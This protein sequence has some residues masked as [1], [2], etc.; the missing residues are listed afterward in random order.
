[1]KRLPYLM[2]YGLDPAY[3]VYVPDCPHCGSPGAGSC[4]NRGVVFC[5]GA[6]EENG[7]TTCPGCD[8]QLTANPNV[9]AV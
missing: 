7:K 4:G 1:M 6:R 9:A 8:T 3:H 2:R 5:G